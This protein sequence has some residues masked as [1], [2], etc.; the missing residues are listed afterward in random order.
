MSAKLDMRALV[1][2]GA[3]VAIGGNSLSRK[4]MELVRELADVGVRDLRVVCFLGSVDVEYLLAAGVVGELHTAGVSLEASGLAPR[5][6][7][8]RQAGE[9]PIV[10]WSEGSLHAAI[11]A[12]ARCW[13]SM[14]ASTSPGSGVVP[15]NPNLL[16]VSDPFTGESIVQARA[17]PIDVALLQGSAVDTAGNLHVDGDLGIDD[18]LARAADTVMVSVPSQESHR[19]PTQ[20]A[21][22]RVWIDHVLER[23]GAA[24][25]TGCPPHE[26]VDEAAV[27]A[28]ARS[29]GADLEALRPQEV[30]G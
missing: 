23:P 19:S 18:V 24:W 21:L 17:L 3:T 12:A 4:P 16:V 25:P 1:R 28:W 7:A 14:P 15:S 11:E 2:D 8:A 5:Y 30:V 9:P 27:A 29:K 13:P 20:A 22:S 6:R 26:P 10:R